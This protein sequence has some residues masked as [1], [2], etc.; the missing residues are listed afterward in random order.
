MSFD[1]RRLIALALALAGAAGGSACG[2][3]PAGVQA[4]APSGGWSRQT[5]VP[6]EYLITLAVGANAKAITDVYGKFGV[7]D[8]RN[9]GQS[10]FLVSFDEDPGLEKMEQARTQSAQIKAVQPNFGYRTQGAGNLR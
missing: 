3:T 7:K 2:N 9:L 10:I 5:R 6:G 1:M 8:M 4:A